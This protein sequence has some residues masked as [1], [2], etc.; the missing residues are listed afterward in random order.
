[1]LDTPKL[2]RVWH[3]VANT[4]DNQTHPPTGE[5]GE[6]CKGGGRHAVV[7]HG[8]R[9]MGRSAAAHKAPEGGGA[10]RQGVGVM[11]ETKKVE[12]GEQPRRARRHLHQSSTTH[13]LAN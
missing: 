2:P 11:A 8:V 9:R 13:W 1:M 3:F 10:T 4:P 6:I 5:Q 12:G 7:V